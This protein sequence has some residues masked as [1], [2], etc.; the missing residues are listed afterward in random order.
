MGKISPRNG[1][2]PPAFALHQLINV[3]VEKRRW[4]ALAEPRKLSQSLPGGPWRETKRSKG[5]AGLG[6]AALV[7]AQFLF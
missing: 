2:Q 4:V 1:R 5:L 3:R 6:K 7:V